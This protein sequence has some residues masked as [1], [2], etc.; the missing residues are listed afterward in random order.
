MRRLLYQTGRVITFTF[1]QFSYLPIGE[2]FSVRDFKLFLL[3]NINCFPVEI[4][5]LSTRMIKLLFLQLFRKS[6]SAK[7]RVYWYRL[8]LHS[9]DEVDRTF[10]LFFVSTRRWSIHGQ[11][12]DK[13]DILLFYRSISITYTTSIT[14]ILGHRT[15]K[16]NNSMECIF[17][18]MHIIIFNVTFSYIK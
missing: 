17:S 10:I 18:W 7:L 16:W 2:C 14:E 1:W 15:L 3:G 13:V 9:L 12:V 5:W 6:L 8:G 11:N 4:N